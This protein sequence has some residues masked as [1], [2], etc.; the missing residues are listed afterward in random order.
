MSFC[1]SLTSAVCA[2]R[3]SRSNRKCFLYISREYFMFLMHIH[4]LERWESCAAL[5]CVAC[6]WHLFGES[7]LFPIWSK[8][9]FIL[10]RLSFWCFLQRFSLVDSL[11]SLMQ[12]VMDVL[13]FSHTFSDVTFGMRMHH[14][15]SNRNG[16]RFLHIKSSKHQNGS[17][18]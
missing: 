18:L 10:R 16:V 7:C 6:R 4:H 5:R 12:N 11:L 8:L 2:V 3:W 15:N 13:A 14:K 1:T 9:K 17:N